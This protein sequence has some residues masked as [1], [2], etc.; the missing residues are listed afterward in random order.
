MIY[1][2]SP[3]GAQFP[4]VRRLGSTRSAS[5]DFG[6]RDGYAAFDPAQPVPNP[7][8]G[9]EVHQVTGTTLVHCNFVESYDGSRVRG[10]EMHTPPRTGVVVDTAEGR[11]NPMSDQ[12]PA[13]QVRV[14]LHGAMLRSPR[15]NRH[16]GEFAWALTRD[17]WEW[18]ADEVSGQAGCG[19]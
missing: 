6:L 5:L 12:E 17:R 9:L 19:G 16:Q 10:V 13:K 8:V 11:L 3:N 7:L 14:R 4:V 15:D 18:K 2:T 1:G